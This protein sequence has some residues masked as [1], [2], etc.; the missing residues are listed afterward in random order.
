VQEPLD[1]PNTVYGVPRGTSM[2]D[3]MRRQCADYGPQGLK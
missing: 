1:F 2:R 3:I